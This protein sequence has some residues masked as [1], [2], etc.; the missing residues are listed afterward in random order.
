MSGGATDNSGR[1]RRPRIGIVGDGTWLPPIDPPSKII[2]V[3]LS[4]RS[5]C[6]EYQMER[7]PEV[8]S[9][10]MKPTS[11]LSAHEAPVARSPT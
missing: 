2:G 5:R 11:S 8:P 7:I 1:R 9:Y 3:H 10:F 6:V 4:Y